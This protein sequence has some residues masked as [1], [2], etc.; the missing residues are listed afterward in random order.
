MATEVQAT[1]VQPSRDGCLSADIEPPPK[2]HAA[3]RDVRRWRRAR[4]RQFDFS[5]LSRPQCGGRSFSFVQMADTQLGAIG[6]HTTKSWDGPGEELELC[7]KA[8]EHINRLRPAFVICCGDLTDAFDRE[9]R[10]PQ[11]A[12]FKRVF[13]KVSADIPFLCVCGNHDVGNR[14]TPES[15]MEYQTDFG[16]DYYE[17]TSGVEGCRLRGI[18]V[19]SNLMY[20]HSGAPDLLR[21]QFTWLEQSLA[22]LDRDRAEGSVQQA[23]LFMHHPIFLESPDEPDDL[24]MWEVCTPTC[25]FSI[26]LN[27]FHLPLDSRQRLVSLLSKHG[28]KMIFSGHH[29]VNKVVRDPSSGLEQVITSAIGLQLGTDHPGFR[30]V[31]VLPD[32]LEHNYFTLD[33]MPEKL[34]ASGLAA[35]AF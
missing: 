5:D 32:R 4:E 20:D 24:G 23:A 22:R 16:D 26:P 21:D 15:I 34:T 33:E 25:K 8:I 14:P 29:H 3:A 7:E 6:S 13:D 17:F 12:D 10:Q 9:T 1:E 2:R 30:I 27:Y 28:V 19:N 18:I 11:V 31:T 35:C